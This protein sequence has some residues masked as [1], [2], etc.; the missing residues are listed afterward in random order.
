MTTF[1]LNQKS[2]QNFLKSTFL[3]L[4]L[5][6]QVPSDAFGPR[7][8]LCRFSIRRFVFSMH[9]RGP[10]LGLQGIE[11]VH[12]LQNDSIILP[13][14]R[15]LTASRSEVIAL[16]LAIRAG[17]NRAQ[18]VRAS[19]LNTMAKLAAERAESI[20]KLIGGEG[21]MIKIRQ[22]KHFEQFNGS[23]INIQNHF[24]LQKTAF[25]ITVS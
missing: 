3:Y 22:N 1:T 16:I 23:K 13:S 11:L 14:G 12:V 17:M 4:D 10:D 21:K 9:S 8:H 20:V 24:K 2:L 19:T 18:P 7:V 6:Q 15:G 5:L 25:E